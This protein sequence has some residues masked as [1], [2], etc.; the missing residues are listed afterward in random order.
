MQVSRYAIAALA[1]VSLAGCAVAPPGPSVI[2]SPG[3]GKSFDVFQ[4][5]DAS[6]RQYAEAQTGISPSDAANQSLFSSGALGTALGAAT[7]AAIGAATG[8][9]AAGAAIGAASGL[10]LGTIGGAGAA[11]YSG[12]AT[13]Y[14]YDVSYTQC[15]SAKGE[16]VQQATV[17]DYGY[18]SYGYPYYGYPYY[19][20]PAYPYYGPSW[21]PWPTY[22][23]FGFGFGG[24]HGGYR[25]GYH[26][27]YRGG[28]GHGGGRHGGSSHH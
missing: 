12:S 20:Y 14:R 5:D 28:G 26:G 1:V 7:G 15:M 25:G 2:A 27:G 18:A 13:Q 16:N 3:D 11:Q 4:A 10:G 24:Y 9:P 6:C 19:S 17:P 21:Y 8:N 22:L 23:N